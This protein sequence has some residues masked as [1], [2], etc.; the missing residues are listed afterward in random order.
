MDFLAGKILHYPLDRGMGGHI[1]HMQWGKAFPLP[2]K[3][4]QLTHSTRKINVD[5]TLQ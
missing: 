5:M 1:G 4:T 2:G 3:L